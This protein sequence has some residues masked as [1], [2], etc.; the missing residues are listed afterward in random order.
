MIRALFFDLDGTLLTD[1]KQLSAAVAAA[2]RAC[3]ARGIKLF[4]ATARPPSLS[5]MLAWPPETLALFDGGVFCNGSVLQLGGQTDYF[6]LPEG[7]VR[8]CTAAVSSH[9]GVNLALQLPD[10]AHAFRFDLDD[11]AFAPWGISTADVLP[12]ECAVSQRVLKMLV[13]YK[14]LIDSAETLPPQ[15]VERLG[16]L[17]RSRARFWVTDGGRVVQIVPLEAGKAAGVETICRRL[18]LQRE[19]AAVFG[20]DQN[21]LEMLSS[22][23]NSVAMGNAGA[24]VQ[25]AARFVTRTNA[26]DGVA[27][28][29]RELLHLI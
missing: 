25:A 11:F 10:N 26:Q 13:F 2:L 8:D 5:K 28:A 15:L 9:D 19:E 3:R 24:D 21:D 20:D 22:F 14:N 7:V 18:Q 12:L 16:M 27:F 29:L 4:V 6:S 17:C 23:P 1:D